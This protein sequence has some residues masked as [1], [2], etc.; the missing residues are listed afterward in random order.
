M[1]RTVFAHHS[2]SPM[3]ALLS[4]GAPATPRAAGILYEL[5]H[6][7]AATA[8][9]QVKA[10]GHPQL[11]TELVIRSN[12]KTS[13]DDVYPAMHRPFAS[14]DIFNVQP[15]E[16]GFYCLCSKREASDTPGAATVAQRHAELLTSAG[17]DYVAIDITNWPQVNAATDVA[18][19][20]PLEVLFDMWLDLRS[21]G[22]STPYIAA[23]CVSPTASYGGGMQTTWKWLLDHVYNNATRAPLLWSRLPG[24]PTFFLPAN[25]HYNASVDAL[26]QRNG[27]RHNIDTIKMWAL[28]VYNSS[29]T[30]GFFAPC[31]L[32]DGSFTTS[33][34]GTS[35]PCDQFPAMSPDGSSVVEVSASGGYM[36]SQ[37]SP[38]QRQATCVGS[39]CND[40]SR[41]CSSRWVHPTCSSHLLMST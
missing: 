41:A 13:L 8:M 33:M 28:N 7:E 4:V 35:A 25:D 40:S 9:A 38:L 11:T 21:R 17:F 23:W 3:L 18:V 5:W 15:A 27:G 20:R 19:L 22:I 37:C 31:T 14:C 34:V 24:R 30:W 32:S 1:L 10:R 26:I 12:G 36:V 6:C 2:A 29:T 16:L 39:R